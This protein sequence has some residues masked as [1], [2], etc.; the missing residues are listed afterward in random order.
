M[1]YKQGKYK[2]VNQEKYKGNTN[3]IIYRSLW[4]KK[5]MIFFD[6]SPNI[7][8]WNSE[9]IVVPY[10]SPI[11][12]KIHSYFPDFVF[13]NRSRKI[14]MIE[15]KPYKETN[16]PKRSKRGYKEALLTYVTNQTKWK[17]ALEFCKKQGWAFFCLD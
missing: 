14:F 7:L 15:V 6:Q 5:V 17:F 3:N 16:P 11:D 12:N 10:H 9:G 8:W 13:M 2:I 4:E 1:R